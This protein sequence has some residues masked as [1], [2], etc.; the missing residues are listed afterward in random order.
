METET[1]K[2][3][4]QLVSVKDTQT[5]TDAIQLVADT[6]RNGGLAAIPTETVY[7]IAA[8]ALDENAVSR[9]FSVKGRPQDNPLIVHIAEI[10]DLEP[11]VRETSPNARKLAEAFFPGALTIIF[12]AAIK[13]IIIEAKKKP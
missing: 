1:T 11:L 10:A 12:P 3:N 9:I 6:L 8:N 5:D 13:P 7:G 2:I 4:T